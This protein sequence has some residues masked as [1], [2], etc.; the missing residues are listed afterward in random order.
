MRL[1]GFSPRARKE[2]HSCTSEV[3]CAALEKAKYYRDDEPAMANLC[4]YY[5][6]KTALTTIW[7]N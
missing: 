5:V 3:P 4:V 2:E 7:V 1:Q 6:G